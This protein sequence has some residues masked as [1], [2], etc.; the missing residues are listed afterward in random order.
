MRVAK[1]L[2]ICVYFGKQEQSGGN[3]A[4]SINT[5]IA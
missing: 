1:P 4:P 2:T 3:I 5:E